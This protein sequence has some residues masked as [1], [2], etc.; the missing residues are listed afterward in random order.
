MPVALDKIQGDTFGRGFPKN[1]ETF[2]FFTITEAKNH[3]NKQF[4]QVLPDVAKEISTLQKVLGDWAK[5]DDP[6]T[7]SPDK[8]D[9]RG[10][11]LD[12]SNALIAFSMAGLKKV[13][14]ATMNESKTVGANLNRFKDSCRVV[15]WNLASLMCQTGRSHWAWRR[16]R[17]TCLTPHKPNGSLLSCH[18][19]DH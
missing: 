12:T 4:H 8:I 7:P 17:Q 1:D 15:H 10:T 5:I 2:Y 13:N 19:R 3:N 18:K 14:A 16:T 11:S 9:F 6:K